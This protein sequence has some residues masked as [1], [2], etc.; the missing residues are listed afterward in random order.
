MKNTPK[1][2][3]RASLRRPFVVTVATVAGA[4]AVPACG[5]SIEGVG[6]DQDT[7]LTGNP[8]PPE[9]CPTAEPKKGEACRLPAGTECGYHDCGGVP[10]MTATCGADSRW[11]I[12]H[13]SCNPP[14]PPEACPT[15]KPLAGDFCNVDPAATC[16]YD[17][18]DGAPSTTAVCTN[19]QWEITSLSCNPP[20][21]PEDCPQA[22]PV[23]GDACNLDPTEACEYG[24]CMGTPTITAMCKPD[25]TWQVLEMSC[26]PPPPPQP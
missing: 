17:D 1:L 21:P 12:M 8:P 16:G 5:G 7:R 22:K 15:D 14:P 3:S 10:A 24:D 2:L 25:K 6:G 18:C 13:V 19:Y 11:D 23:A 20:P 9:A 4:I 26:N